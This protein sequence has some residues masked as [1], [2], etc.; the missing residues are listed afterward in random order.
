MNMTKYSYE[1]CT[2]SVHLPPSLV[3]RLRIVRV[4]R[5][6]DRV[7]SS[8]PWA[9]RETT[10]KKWDSLGPP[11]EMEVFAHRQTDKCAWQRSCW[12]FEWH[13]TERFC[14]G[15]YWLRQYLEHLKHTYSSTVEVRPKSIEA[16]IPLYI[17]MYVCIYGY[18]DI[19]THPFCLLLVVAQNTSSRWDVRLS[20]P[21]EQYM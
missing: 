15:Q 9:S 4:S 5:R 8:L 1:R 18:I 16:S 13:S 11:E 17:I 19:T 3:R 2:P 14:R 12:D 10:Q 21:L 7:I 6:A 20:G